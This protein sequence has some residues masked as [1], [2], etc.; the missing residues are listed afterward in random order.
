MKVIKTTAVPL[1]RYEPPNK[2]LNKF[3]F[4]IKI[5][6]T[7]RDWNELVYLMRIGISD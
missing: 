6:V 3:T 5:D 1:Q 4:Q 7:D 2:D